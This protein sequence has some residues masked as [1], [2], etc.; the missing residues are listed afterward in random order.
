M[1]VSS[2]VCVRVCPGVQGGRRVRSRVCGSFNDKYYS[3]VLTA[4]PE[5]DAHDPGDQS[6]ILMITKDRK[7][8]TQ[9]HESNPNRRKLF[10]SVLLYWCLQLA[11]LDYV[12]PVSRSTPTLFQMNHS[13]AREEI[14]N[15]KIP[16]NVP[17]TLP[18]TCLEQE[19]PSTRMQQDSIQHLRCT[20]VDP[21]GAPIQALQSRSRT[22]WICSNLSKNGTQMASESK[23]PTNNLCSRQQ[24]AQSNSLST[25]LMADHCLYWYQTCTIPPDSLEIFCQFMNCSDN[26]SGRLFS[27]AMPACSGLRM[28]RKSPSIPRMDTA[29]ISLLFQLKRWLLI[30]PFGTDDLCTLEL[31]Q[32]GGWRASSNNYETRRLTLPSAMDVYTVVHARNLSV[33]LR[34][35]VNRDSLSN[36]GSMSLV[37]EFPPTCV[38]RFPRASTANAMPSCFTTLPQNILPCT[39]YQIR[40]KIQSL[41]RSTSFYSTT[42]NGYRKEWDIG[43]LITEASSKTAASMHFVRSFASSAHSQYRMSPGKTHT[44]N[45]SGAISYEKCDLH[46]PIQMRQSTCGRTLSSK[47]LPFITASWMTTVFHHLRVYMEST[48]TTIRCTR[49]FAWC[50]T[51]CQAEIVQANFHRVHCPLTTVDLTQNVMDTVSLCLTCGDS[52]LRTMLFSTNT[53]TFIMP[54]VASLSL[55]MKWTC[56]SMI[57]L[58]LLQ[59][60]TTK[61]IEMQDTTMM[62]STLIADRSAVYVAHGN[63]TTIPSTMS[64][65]VQSLIPEVIPVSQTTAQLQIQSMVRIKSGIR[66]T[67]ATLVVHFPED[68]QAPVKTKTLMD[69]D[70]DLGLYDTMLSGL[71]T[72]HASAGHQNNVPMSKVTKEDAHSTTSKSHAKQYLEKMCIMAAPQATVCFIPTTEDRASIKLVLNV[73]NAMMTT[74]M[75]LQSSEIGA[76]NQEYRN[77]TFIYSHDRI[78]TSYGHTVSSQLR[79]NLFSSLFVRS[80]ISPTN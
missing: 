63:V 80:P 74:M 65:V 58:V 4:V 9:F 11:L 46:L 56:Q 39:H 37:R 61:R 49:Y 45:E 75:L 24:W 33:P 71:W 76:E 7:H 73:Q 40:R 21:S 20:K 35:H 42:K 8:R 60:S 14:P 15:L 2:S 29:T 57:Q 78:L 52:R 32:C 17:L 50:T 38:D 10:I 28:E 44:Q 70:C 68:T 69:A 16:S 41:M 43:G 64:N 30:Q 55:L 1:S 6:Y 27:V 23:L 31:V 18:F 34:E 62:E 25:T 51:S 36:N 19:Q 12:H 53:K 3:L 13:S 26:T 79:Y 22:D 48:L 67:A 72:N 66:T 5:L 54:C 59:G 47:Q 77:G